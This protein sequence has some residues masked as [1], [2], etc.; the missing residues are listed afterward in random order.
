MKTDKGLLWAAAIF[1]VLLWVTPSIMGAAVTY[2]QS[3]VTPDYDSVHIE[4]WIA[5]GDGTY[6]RADTAVH[7]IPWNTT[8][9]LND[10]ANWIIRYIWF[11]GGDSS[12]GMSPIIF[13]PS[14][15]VSAS[16]D[17]TGS[18]TVTLYSIDTSGT[19]DTL[20]GTMM[21]VRTLAGDEAVWP[22]ATG[23]SGYKVFSLDATTYVINSTKS[24]YTFPVDTV[25]ISSDTT[26]DITSYELVSPSA[27]SATSL[28]V[29][30]G[31]V[32]E[33]AAAG[34]YSAAKY[35]TVTFD[36]PQNVVNTCD[37]VMTLQRV[38][39]VETN[40]SGYFQIT[41]LKSSCVQVN[42]NN[43][44]Y[45]TWVEGADGVKTREHKLDIPDDSSTYKLVF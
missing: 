43:Q 33:M 42:G 39:R 32:Y 13:S 11:S 3:F 23:T 9:A 34:G 1:A 37:S 22:Q 16:L 28:C 35:A 17:G 40:A 4:T 26:L 20:S 31:Y 30:Y 8:V 7:T 38:Q 14:V 6:T 44:K 41:L 18:Y 45:R 24:W 12:V 25:V 36:L 27:P 21:S 19:D 15:S 10:T 2:P 29:V 5:A